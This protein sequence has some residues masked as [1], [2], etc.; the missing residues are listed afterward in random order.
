MVLD[1][2]VVFIE[3]P[4]VKFAATF[5]YLDSTKT[6]LLELVFFRTAKPQFIKDKDCNTMMRV[7]M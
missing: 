5:L 4:T 1:L 7:I 3:V 6:F 2:A